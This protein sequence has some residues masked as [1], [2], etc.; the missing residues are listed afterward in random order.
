MQLGISDGAKKQV[1]GS[2]LDLE[3]FKRKEELAASLWQDLC[4]LRGSGA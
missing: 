3:L 4:A 1:R 2:T